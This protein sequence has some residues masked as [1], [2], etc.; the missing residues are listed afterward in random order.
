MLEKWRDRYVTLYL[1]SSPREAKE[2]ALRTLTKEDIVAIT[3]IIQKRF[4]E[5]GYEPRK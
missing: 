3:P 5:L 4:E 1:K 2:W